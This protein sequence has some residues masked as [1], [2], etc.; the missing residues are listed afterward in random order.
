MPSLQVRE[1]PDPLYRKLAQQ[2]EKE[3]RSL[4]QQAVAIL[5]KGLGIPDDA[6][7]RRRKLLDQIRQSPVKLVGK[8][9]KTPVDMIREDR[10]R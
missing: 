9:M 2:A 1:L 3:H 4:A 5:A 8:R 10:D 6:R 7:E